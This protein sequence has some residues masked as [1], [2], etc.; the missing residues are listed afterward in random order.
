MSFQFTKEG[1]IQILN[2]FKSSMY[3]HFAR[4]DWL[5]WDINLRLNFDFS[6]ICQLTFIYFFPVKMSFFFFSSLSILF[7]MCFFTSIL[8]F[9]DVRNAAY[10]HGFLREA[11]G[12]LRLTFSLMK[13]SCQV[14]RPSCD[15]M[16]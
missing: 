4:L 5:I 15:N 13:L 7:F 1:G 3:F 16:H 10:P 9:I 8:T 14:L 11:A 12:K 6:C 2:I